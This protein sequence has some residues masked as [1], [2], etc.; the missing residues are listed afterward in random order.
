[1]WLASPRIRR[2]RVRAPLASRRNNREAAARGNDD[3]E[4]N[5]KE[6]SVSAFRCIPIPHETA[7]RFRDTG[8]D[9]SGETL[10]RRVVQ[11]KGSPCRHCLRLG[12]PGETV[13]LGRYNLP[14]P[15]G[16]YWTPSPIWVH[17]NDCALFDATNTIPETV[18]GSLVS[19]RAYD[20]DGMCL[21]DLGHVCEGTEVDEPLARAL[22]DDRTAYV[23][24]HTAKPGCWLC[25]VERTT[26]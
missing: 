4:A 1:M 20:P 15:R 26:G 8:R 7:M 2:R 17:A 23:N 18:R 5:R 12:E 22:A 6:A 24:I 25:R 14:L 21:Y 10:H 3:I 13:L 19:V 11:T 16:V 9:D